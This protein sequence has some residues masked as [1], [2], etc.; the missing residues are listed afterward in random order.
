MASSKDTALTFVRVVLGVAALSNGIAS[1]FGV[2]GGGRYA[3]AAADMA[4]KAV[5]PAM[6]YY[7]VSILLV[8]MGAL[9]L[10]GLMVRLAAWLVFAAVVVVGLSESRFGAYFDRHGG[11]E[12]LLALA[13]L[14]VVTATHG[15]GAWRVEFKRDGEGK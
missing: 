2:W 14:C 11:C 8:V 15:P 13:A 1:T 4:G 6:L 3:A 7:T 10:L 9:L 5:P 12:D